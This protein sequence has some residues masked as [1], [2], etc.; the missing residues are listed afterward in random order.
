MNGLKIIVFMVCAA[1][2]VIALPQTA[3]SFT[4]TEPNLP[5]VTVYSDGDRHEVLTCADTVA[6]LLYELGITVY[7]LDRVSH[8]METTVWGGMTIVVERATDVF[9]QI[10][11]AAPFLRFAEPAATVGQ[12]LVQVQRRSR[13]PLIYNGD[14]D[15]LVENGETLVFYTFVTR[16]RT[17]LEAIPYETIENRTSAVW[18]GRSHQRQAGVAGELAHISH[19]VYIGGVEYSN[20]WVETRVNAEPIDAII[21][22]GTGQLGALTDVTAP[23]FHYVRRVRMHATAYTAGYNCTG[24]LPCDPWYRITASGREVE[25]GIVAVDRRVIPL[26]TRL[27]V[28]GYGF[29]LAADVGGAIRGYSIDLFMECILDARRFGRRNLYVWILD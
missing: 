14:Y 16:T 12:V 20:E 8:G 1:I 13:V 3:T 6:D 5:R 19:V 25:H 9:V 7:Y 2:L 11:Q 29:A 28:Q 22:I 23:D 15:R 17:Q 24:K 4:A 10:N 26:G 27:Y 18:A 21:D